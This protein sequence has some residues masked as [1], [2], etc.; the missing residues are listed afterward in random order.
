MTD[1]LNAPAE[2]EVVDVAALHAE[3]NLFIKRQNEGEFTYKG[4]PND[5]AA[6]QAFELQAFNAVKRG[7]ELAAI[8]RRQN[9]GPAKPK[10]AAAK[11]GR[12]AADPVNINDLLD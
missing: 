1:I 12:K 4:D 9:T 3:F 7:I 5:A 11:G 2:P 6:K 10:R 8:L